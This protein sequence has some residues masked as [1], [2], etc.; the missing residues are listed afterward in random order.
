MR[1]EIRGKFD[2][3]SKMVVLIGDRTW[4]SE[5]VRWEV[6][7]FYEMKNRLPGE[8]WKRIRG[9]KLKGSSN[10]AI[11]DVLGGKSTKCI[12]WDP[13]LMDKWLDLDPNR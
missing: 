1:D 12:D 10:A 6:S 5:W 11:P 4:Q 13:D 9:M 3:A 2:R 8:A 7:I